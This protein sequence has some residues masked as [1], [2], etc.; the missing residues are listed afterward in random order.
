[1]TSIRSLRH[2]AARVPLSPAELV[3]EYAP[4]TG[5]DVHFHARSPWFS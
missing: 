5:R 1:M 3:G 4:R 2:L